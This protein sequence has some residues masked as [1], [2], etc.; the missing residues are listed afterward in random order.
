MEVA[1]ALTSGLLMST[2]LYAM[3]KKHLYQI[4]IGVMLLGHGANLMVFLTG[5][6]S[7]GKA[8]FIEKGATGLAQG[9]ADPIPQALVLTSIVIGFGLTSFLLVLFH[10]SIAIVG[11][12]NTDDFR[13]GGEEEH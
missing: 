7:D 1:L 8:A 9:S 5:G 10:Q 13:M 12:A 4:I 11:S 2:G 3:L 6:L